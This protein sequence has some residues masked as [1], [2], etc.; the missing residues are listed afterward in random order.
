MEHVVYKGNFITVTEEDINGKIILIKELRVHEHPTESWK[1]VG[2]VHE[3]GDSL[4]AA[5]NKELREELKMRGT[6]IPFM[7]I[8]RKGTFCESTSIVLAKDLTHDPL[9]NPDGEHVIL[10]MQEFSV[11]EIYQ[12]ALG[13]E[14]PWGSISYALIKFYHDVKKRII[15]L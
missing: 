1:L 9:P 13:G 3:E 5:A 11:D 12:K 14:F 15:N 2:G 8:N 10:G 7:S 6:I 4:E